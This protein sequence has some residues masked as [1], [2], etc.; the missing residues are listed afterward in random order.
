M[1][2][3]PFLASSPGDLDTFPRHHCI[4]ATALLLA[5]GAAEVR[6]GAQGEAAHKAGVGGP[7]FFFYSVS[8]F[9]LFPLVSSL[10]NLLF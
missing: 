6:P 9:F 5:V 4:V 8:F 3:V 2:A 1:T 10:I 7:L